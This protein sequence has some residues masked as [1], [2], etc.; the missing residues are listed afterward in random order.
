[1][2]N[3]SLY[4]NTTISFDPMPSF[5]KYQAKANSFA[6]FLSDFSLVLLSILSLYLV[7]SIKLLIS[8]PCKAADN[9]QIEENIFVEPTAQY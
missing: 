3:L 1:M 5:A 2:D 7:L 6:W 4:G 8:N 9:S